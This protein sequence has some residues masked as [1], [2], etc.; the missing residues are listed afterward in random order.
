[1]EKGRLERQCTIL[2]EREDCSTLRISSTGFVENNETILDL[3]IKES[4]QK[5]ETLS[6]VQ[7]LQF[8]DHESVKQFAQVLLRCFSQIRH[9]RLLD[10]QLADTPHLL[11]PLFHALSSAPLLESIDIM[12][13]DTVCLVSAEVLKRISVSSLSL[14]GCGL[15]QA[16]L[17]ILRNKPL[18]FLSIRCNSNLCWKS[19]YESLFHNYHI[20]FLYNDEASFESHHPEL[21]VHQ[22]RCAETSLLTSVEMIVALNRLGRREA[23]QGTRDIFDY[24]EYVNESPTSLFWTLRQMKLVG[25]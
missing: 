22:P 18:Y 11:D 25:R 15:Q 8:L 14:W 5:L 9:F 6:I 17:E 20:Q 3:L 2:V 7:G 19:Y 23:M 10:P 12:A 13:G 4:Q 21:T 16:H 24:M 1:M